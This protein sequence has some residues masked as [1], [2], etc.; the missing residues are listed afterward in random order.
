MNMKIITS[1][2]NEQLKL[3]AKLLQNAKSRREHRAT[4]LEGVHL[5][6]A[7]LNANQLPKRV[8]IPKN[9][10]VSPEIQRIINRLP[11]HLITLVEPGVLNKISQLT[12]SEDIM[13]WIELPIS[14]NLPISDDCVVLENIQDSGNIGTILRSAAAAGVVQIV[15]SKG[16]ADV[17]SPKVLRAGMGA[18]FLL[19]IHERVDLLAWRESFSGSVLV[20]AL[21]KKN[22]VSLYD[23]QLDLTRSVAWVFGNEGSGVSADMLAQAS[24]A[25]R[26]PMLGAT[27]SLNVAMAATIC[28]FEQMRQRLN[29]S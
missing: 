19:K 3:I 16:C 12:E 15:L 22:N 29:A 27:E 26:I 24:A 14:G 1:I 28:L 20:T 4:V 6:D 7:Y 9:R 10:L 17:W 11:E 13:T 18:H 21:T 8:F 5:L 23:K 25:V 2:H